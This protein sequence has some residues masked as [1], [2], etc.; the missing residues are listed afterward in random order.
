M[1]RLVVALLFFSCCF[2]FVS[3]KQIEIQQPKQHEKGVG[4]TLCTTVVSLAHT[5][6][7][8]N[9]TRDGLTTVVRQLCPFINPPEY[10]PK[11]C[12]RMIEIFAPV[13]IDV[14]LARKEIQPKTICHMIGLCDKPD[15][16]K[17]SVES[18]KAIKYFEKIKRLALLQVKNMKH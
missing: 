8:Q 3:S 10:R 6:V 1:N 9:A 7:R 18:Q 4:C 16:S 5:L 17:N 13:V 15:S 11:V 14:F 2:L 12:P